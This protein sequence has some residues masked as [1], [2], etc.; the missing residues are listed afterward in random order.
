MKAHASSVAS[1]DIEVI[2]KA[3]TDPCSGGKAD[4][5]VVV[6]VIKWQTFKFNLIEALV[7]RGDNHPM[8]HSQGEYGTREMRPQSR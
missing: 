6:A 7:S 1:V 5:L 4:W 2:L 3:D 8:W